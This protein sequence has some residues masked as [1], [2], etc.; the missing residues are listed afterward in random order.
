MRRQREFAKTKKIRLSK[1]L[2][3]RKLAESYLSTECGRDVENYNRVIRLAPASGQGEACA[4]K[5]K[6]NDHIPSPNSW[7][8]VG[9]LANVEDNDP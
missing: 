7:D 4:N 5:G 8:W 2:G 9:G 1:T 3:R 6:A